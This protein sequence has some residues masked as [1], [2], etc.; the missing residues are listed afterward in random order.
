[1]FSLKSSLRG[2]D[3]VQ[4]KLYVDPTSSE[5]FESRWI[6]ITRAR[7]GASGIRQR[8]SRLIC[9]SIRLAARYI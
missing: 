2:G 8:G 3:E 5:G 1:M 4:A 7:G 9:S 6:R